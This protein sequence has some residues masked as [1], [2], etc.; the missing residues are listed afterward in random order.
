[1]PEN[2]ASLRLIDK[3]NYIQERLRLITNIHI[4]QLLLLEQKFTEDFE[5]LQQQL[6]QLEEMIRPVEPDQ[7]FLKDLHKNN[8]KDLD[9]SNKLFEHM[10]GIEQSVKRAKE[11]C[12]GT[13]TKDNLSDKVSNDLEKKPYNNAEKSESLNALLPL[14]FVEIQAATKIYCPNASKN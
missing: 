10:G 4:N 1:M 8:P 3:V 2:T 12:D 14:Y 9:L 7:L 5:D 6:Q 13:I 11:Y